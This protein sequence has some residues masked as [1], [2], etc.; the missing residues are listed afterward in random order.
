M[1]AVGLHLRAQQELLHPRVAGCCAAEDAADDAR[2]LR[3]WLDNCPMCGLPRSKY[4]RRSATMSKAH[5]LTS[6]TALRILVSSR[7]TCSADSS[8]DA[9]SCH[10]TLPS[11]T[12]WLLA[13]ADAQVA[14]MRQQTTCLS[15]AV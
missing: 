1:R 4:C 13:A 12:P 9:P 6:A 14:H 2:P 7:H 8:T 10:R 5:D 15:C 11:V 3:C